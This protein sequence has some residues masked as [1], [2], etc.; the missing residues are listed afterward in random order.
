ML[1]K[2]QNYMHTKQ[3][4]TVFKNMLKQNDTHFKRR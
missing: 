3:K 2:N 4:Q 1:F